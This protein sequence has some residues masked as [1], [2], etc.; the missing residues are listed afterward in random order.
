MSLTQ[1]DPI[2]QP[3]A[4]TATGSYINV[5]PDSDPG[6]GLASYEL[7]FPPL[8]FTPLG[9][10]GQPPFGADFNGILNAAT[11]NLQWLQAGLLF[12]F[13]ASLSTALSGYPAGALVP[14][15]D[16]STVWIS[17]AGSNT[18]DPATLANI[19]TYWFPAIGEATVG[20]IRI[21]AV[22]GSANAIVLTSS[23]NPAPM[24]GG[25]AIEQAL[26]FVVGTTNT[27]TVTV[28]VD[29]APAVAL[30]NNV[31]AALTS[32]DLIAGTLHQVIYNGTDWQVVTAVPSQSG[33]YGR[34]H[35]AG[36]LTSS[37]PTPLNPCML[38]LAGSITPSTT[39]R[40]KI[41]VTGTATNGTSGDTPVIRGR[42]GTGAA[43]ALGDVVTGTQFGADATVYLSGTTDFASFVVQD[44]LTGLT[45]G[46]AYWIDL[47]VNG[48]TS[49]FDSQDLIVTAIEF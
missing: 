20:L 41:E 5:I 1:P 25:T 48:T 17:K 11:A 42:Y 16:F 36:P 28:A 21:A 9:S 37:H 33:S 38:G 26:F 14:S 47:D 49:N 7:G 29:G 22:S 6:G 18:H 2:L 27:S 8:T 34:T 46:T 44:I 32:G 15:A 45:A 12:T 24:G 31:G 19:G 35:V 3:F 10:G 4:A 39:R 40:V 30:H 43:P 23:I 13:Q